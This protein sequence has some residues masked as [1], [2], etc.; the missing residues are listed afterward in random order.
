MARLLLFCS[1]T[2]EQNMAIKRQKTCKIWQCKLENIVKYGNDKK[3]INTFKPINE[4]V[5]DKGLLRL[6]FIVQKEEKAILILSRRVSR[7]HHPFSHNP[8]DTL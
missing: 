7:T 5:K 4:Q 6:Y 1:T 2:R 8:L 3:I